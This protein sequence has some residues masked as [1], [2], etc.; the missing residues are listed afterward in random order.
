MKKVLVTMS[1]LAIALSVSSASFADTLLL[2]AKDNC[3][4]KLSSFSYYQTIAPKCQT[5]IFG[6]YMPV[7]KCCPAAP[8]CCSPCAAAPV[9]P[10]CCE[11][12]KPACKMHMKKKFKKHKKAACGCGCGCNCGCN[13]K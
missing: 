1:A 12:T 4:C 9:E 11:Q 2:P 8:V 6:Y 13:S 3:G 5:R 10:C 7:N